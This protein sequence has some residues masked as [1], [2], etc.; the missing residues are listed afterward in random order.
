MKTKMKKDWFGRE[1]NTEELHNDSKVWVS[2]INLI[3]DEIRFLEHLLSANYI[4]FL[5]AGLHKKIEENVKQISL[6]KNLG[7]ELQDLIREQE[8]ILSE[9]IT[10]ESVT[11]NINYIENHKKLEVEI[12]TYIKK[13][14]DLKQQ[15]FKVVENVM[16]KTAQKKLPGTD[17]IQKLLDK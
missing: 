13:Y 11:G 15:I 16:K 4:D 1:K 7:T 2:E 9:L 5:A 12:N 8:K 17:E 10:T 6:Q 14:K 3:K